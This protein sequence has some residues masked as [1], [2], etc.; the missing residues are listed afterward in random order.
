MLQRQG[1]SPRGGRSW[2]PAETFSAENVLTQR[3]DP[4]HRRSTL[5]S[6]RREADGGG[7]GGAHRHDTG[8]PLVELLITADCPVGPL[9]SALLR[10]TLNELGL[11]QVSVRVSEI[12]TAYEA[13]RR[14]F[15]GSPTILINGH[16][17][18]DSSDPTPALTCRRYPTDTGLPDQHRLAA[19]IHA[20][21]VD[22]ARGP[23]F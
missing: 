20:A 2:C 3:P 15:A 19:A 23:T 22:G 17:P 14:G 1:L 12:A 16:D 6:N 7:S 10:V 13:R 8:C 9:A 4:A 5:L 11:H 18:W 21:I